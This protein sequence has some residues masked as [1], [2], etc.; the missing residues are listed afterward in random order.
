MTYRDNIDPKIW[1][2]P[3]WEFLNAVT[4]G[5][6]YKADY[7]ERKQMVAF[8]TSLG[9]VLP[10]STCRQNYNE[11]LKA[12][13]PSQH[14]SGRADV[15]NWFKMYKNHKKPNSKT[16]ISQNTMENILRNLI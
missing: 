2:P 3:G 4:G 6:P 8:L 12:F 15:E 14:V 1:G 11:F 5:Y 7:E 9:N 16:T 10:C 13:P